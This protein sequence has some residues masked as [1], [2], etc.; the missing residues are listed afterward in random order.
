MIFPLQIFVIMISMSKSFVLGVLV[1][2]VTW[3]ISLLLYWNLTSQG[4]DTNA[5]PASAAV[6]HGFSQ[7]TASSS[8]SAPL[9]RPVGNFVDASVAV[10]DHRN[11]KKHDKVHHDIK[12]LY[13]EKWRRSEKDKKRRKISQHLVDELRPRNVEI[14]GKTYIEFNDFMC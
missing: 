14:L 13:L 3:T 11:H 12:D 6:L 1:A 5:S 8:N 9:I 2:S 4:A 7:H 10:D